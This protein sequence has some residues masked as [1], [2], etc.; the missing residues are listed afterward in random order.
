VFSFFQQKELT[1]E[2]SDDA[3]L[4]VRL[5]YLVKKKQTAKELLW[6]SP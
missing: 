5:T 4:F 6:D 3:K 2:T 1:Y